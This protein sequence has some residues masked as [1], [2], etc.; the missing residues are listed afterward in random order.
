MT[1]TAMTE[2]VY[3]VKDLAGCVVVTTK[4]ETLGVLKDVLPTGANDVYVVGEGAAEVLI[5]ALKTVVKSIDIA[6]KR[7]EVEL[8]EGLRAI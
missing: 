6:N 5:P 7:I 8:P 4:G 2:T 1:A 3:L